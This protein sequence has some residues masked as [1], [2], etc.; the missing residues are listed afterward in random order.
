MDLGSSSPIISGIV[1]GVIAVW[2][3]GKLAKKTSRHDKEAADL[4]PEY[5]GR[6]LLSNLLFFACIGGGVGLF[7]QGYFHRNDWSGGGLILGAALVAPAL[8][9]F[10]ASV[11]GG[12]QRVRDAFRAYASTEGI[13]LWGLLG[14]FAFGVFCLFLGGIGVISR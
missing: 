12:S 13:P 2:L 5:K 14:F 10:L 3:L 1:G 11:G 9:L 6:I 4:V 8:F 7:D